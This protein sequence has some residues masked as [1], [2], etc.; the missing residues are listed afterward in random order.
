[1]GKEREAKDYMFRSLALFLVIASVVALVAGWSIYRQSTKAAPSSTMTVS[2]EGKVTVKPDLAMVYFSVVSQGSDSETV[3]GDNDQKMTEAVNYLKQQGVDEADIKTTSY[4]LNPQYDYSWCDR[5][6]L[7]SYSS[8]PAKLSGY[9]MTQSVELKLRDLSKIGEI[10]GTLPNKGVNQISYISFTIDDEDIPKIEARKQALEKA[11]AKA[12]AMAG[13]AN[14][15]L[16]KVLNI[17]DS[18]SY[19]VPYASY[20]T[21]EVSS[22]YGAGDYAAVEVGSNEV[23]VTVSITYEIK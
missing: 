6:S 22:A 7:S 8:C 3:Q 20:S 1:M 17:S 12:L 18:N 2:A 11:T 4:N 16:G 14:V 19:Y 10:I 21:K 13:A 15:R 23:T 5:D 9:L